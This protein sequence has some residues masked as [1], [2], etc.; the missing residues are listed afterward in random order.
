MKKIMKTIGLLLVL[1]WF[2]A[3]CSKTLPT[4]IPTEQPEPSDTTVTTPTTQPSTQPITQ[5]STETATQPSEPLVGWREAD[6][7]RYYYSDAGQPLTGWVTVE[8]A[9][10]YFHED[11][12]MHVG[13]LE[14]DSERYYLREDGTMAVG[15]MVIDDVSHFFTA[16]GKYVVLVNRWHPVPADL[17]LELVEFQGYRVDA[18]CAEALGEML[19]DCTAAGYDWHINSAY[20]SLEKQQSIWDRRYQNYICAGYSSEEAERL[21]GQSVAVPGTSEHHLGLAVDIDGEVGVLQ[22]LSEHCW[23]YGFIVRYPEGKTDVTGIIYEPWHFRYVGNEL[24][25]QLHETGLCM[26]EYM[27]MLTQ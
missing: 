24:A 9:Q 2:F 26:E 20:R 4:D 23:D 22:W 25:A 17:K 19:S 11:G 12:A 6:G 8:G 21:V 13:W 27:Q 10:Y 16:K 3:A 15:E 7:N 1:I 18:A 14:L 5:P